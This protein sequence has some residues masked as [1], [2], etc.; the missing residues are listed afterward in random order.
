MLFSPRR[1]S[2]LDSS[3]FNCYLSPINDIALS[4]EYDLDHDADWDA[5][6]ALGEKCDEEGTKS[7]WKTAPKTY[8]QLILDG[9]NS[10]EDSSSGC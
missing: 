4:V 2:G 1:R 10:V 6:A 7:A 5:F 9:G 8:R 3:G